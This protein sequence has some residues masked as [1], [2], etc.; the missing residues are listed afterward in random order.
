MAMLLLIG[1]ILTYVVG[2][3]L[4]ITACFKPSEAAVLRRGR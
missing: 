3:L 4:V 1:T 2:G